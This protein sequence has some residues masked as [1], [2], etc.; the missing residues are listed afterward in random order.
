[1]YIYFHDKHGFNYWGLWLERKNKILEIS[2][3]LKRKYG[4]CWARVSNSN[5]FC[6][7]PLGI[8]ILNCRSFF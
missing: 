6:N 1:M 2:I 7:H 4:C 5:D 3:D 8:I